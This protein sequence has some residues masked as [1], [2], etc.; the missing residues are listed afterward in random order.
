[1]KKSILILTAAVV[2]GLVTPSFGQSAH[3]IEQRTKAM[4]TYLHL[5]GQ[6]ERAV[7]SILFSATQRKK[8]IRNNLSLSSR[9][10][11]YQLKELNKETRNQIEGVLTP[12]QARAYRADG[13]FKNW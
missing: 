8:S 10:V 11:K 9:D 13:D 2:C 12:G 5:S 3:D 1:M 7:R 4:R 6:Q